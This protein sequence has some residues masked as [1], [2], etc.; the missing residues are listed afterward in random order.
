MIVVQ[1]VFYLISVLCVTNIM[2]IT[3]SVKLIFS[4]LTGQWTT[5][6][7]DFWNFWKAEH[8]SLKKHILICFKH[9]YYIFNHLRNDNFERPVPILR[10]YNNIL[11]SH[12]SQINILFKIK[13]IIM[14]KKIIYFILH[15][16]HSNT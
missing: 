16:Y 10:I 15:K 2:S 9:F 14:K 13:K 7:N 12:W 3:I 1:F 11:I 8:C 4:G 5:C 6:D